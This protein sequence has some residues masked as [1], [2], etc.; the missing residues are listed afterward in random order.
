[1]QAIG[2]YQ[3]GEELGRGPAGVVHRAL[4]PLLDRPLAIRLLARERA[5]AAALPELRRE[6]Q[7]LARLR[8]PAVPQVLAVGEQAG[9]VWVALDLV[10]GQPLG[11][12]LARG[13][14][15]PRDAARVVLELAQALEQAHALGLAHGDL[16][17]DEVRL[18]PDGAAH[19]SQ[20]GLHRL[21]GSVSTR[22]TA[23]G[24]LLGPAG[25][26]APEQLDAR[27][28][29]TAWRADPASDVHALGALL[30]RLVGGRAPFGEPGEPALVVLDRV[31][32]HP[33]RLEAVHARD[34][35]LA[36]LCARCLAKRPEERPTAGQVVQE[37]A[38]WLDPAHRRGPAR[39]QAWAA[40]GL[41]L[42]LLPAGL[43][44]RAATRGQAVVPLTTVAP[45]PA[46][47]Q[48]RAVYDAAAALEARGEHRPALALVE[49]GLDRWPYEPLL[50]ALRGRLRLEIG[51]P[52]AEPILADL[53]AALRLH[54]DSL[55]LRA[56]LQILQAVAGVGIDHSAVHELVSSEPGREPTQ[57]VV[58]A[59]IAWHVY[60][61][62]RGDEDAARLAVERALVLHPDH[63]P[64]LLRRAALREGAGDV[65]GA[66]VDL[67]RARSM[68][69]RAP[70]VFLARAG[71]LRRHG[72][73]RGSLAEADQ[74]LA[75]EPGD[76]RL[77]AERAMTLAELG[78]LE[79]AQEAAQ[80]ALAAWPELPLAVAA[81]ALLRL[82]TG[83]ADEA[84]QAEEALTQAL[85]LRAVSVDLRR[86]RARAR[87]AQGNDRGA[88]ED[89]RAV[90]FELQPGDPLARSAR[91]ELQ[92]LERR[93]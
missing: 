81:G 2:P 79:P 50:S 31:L 21:L 28:R 52:E 83:E 41:L 14:L 92:E 46:L 73:L 45:P 49:E 4:D 17:V 48:P 77:L 37:L 54:P 68:G 64:T 71:Y 9:Q 56:Q 70:A 88:A 69:S 75:L 87:R 58:G 55:P 80:Q 43:W 47:G 66:G 61:A 30:A 86:M 13:P 62:A 57:A 15:H 53:E 74:G 67:E 91:E 18:G 5:S 63:V 78:D 25:E 51:A 24:E 16:R 44:W 84:R 72:D 23:D 1:M 93:R 59:L 89:L 20:L 11:E 90:L 10:E 39:L 40:L 27:R 65:S 12:L 33:P 60:L 32:N 3:L 76:P 22:V 38:A 26:L 85:E 82:A 7:Q 8:H 35:R 19:M 42:A 34:R 29:D 36:A 6:A